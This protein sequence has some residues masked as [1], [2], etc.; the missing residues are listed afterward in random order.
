[1]LWPYS[2]RRHCSSLDAPVRL[3]LLLLRNYSSTSR[4]APGGSEN[5]SDKNEGFLV[6]LLGM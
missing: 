2:S 1:M 5:S 6:V 4:M 3:V